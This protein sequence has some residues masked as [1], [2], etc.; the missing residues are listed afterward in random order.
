[1]MSGTVTVKVLHNEGYFYTAESRLTQVL[2]F[3]SDFPACGHVQML[4]DIVYR[5]LTNTDD[6]STDWDDLDWAIRYRADERNR[7]LD[8]GD[9]VVVGEQAWAIESI[10]WRRVTVHA[11]QIS[12]R[13]A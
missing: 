11:A 3:E 7:A 13:S 12:N 6:P 9:V 8:V 1:M 10:A 5:Q 2:E 4:L